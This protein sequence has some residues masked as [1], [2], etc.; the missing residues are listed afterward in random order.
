[1]HPK[2]H[3][4][5]LKYEESRWEGGTEYFDAGRATLQKEEG[6]SKH[7]RGKEV[8]KE[9]TGRITEGIQN[10]VILRR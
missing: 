6:E 8:R 9:I 2:Q 4:S 10:L 7:F 5:F 1:M 3:L